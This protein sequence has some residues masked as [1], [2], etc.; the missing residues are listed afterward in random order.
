MKPTKHYSS[1][2]GFVVQY[3]STDPFIVP[4]TFASIWNLYT[5]LGVKPVTVNV[6]SAVDIAVPLGAAPYAPAVDT[7]NL[8]FKEAAELGTPAQ[9]NVTDVEVLLTIYKYCTEIVA[10]A[11][12]FIKRA[13]LCN[14]AENRS[15]LAIVNMLLEGSFTSI[16]S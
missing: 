5:V 2:Y 15:P 16:V 7:L 8:T 10:V 4:P 14:I 1:R 6:A 12:F 13:T 9:P 3:V 11:G